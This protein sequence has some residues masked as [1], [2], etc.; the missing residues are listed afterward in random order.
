MKTTFLSL[1]LAFLLL[2]AQSTYAFSN[3]DFLN[4]LEQL[5]QD[6]SILETKLALLQGVAVLPNSATNNF[7][8]S[9]G[10]TVLYTDTS[11]NTAEAAKKCEA[12]AFDTAYMWQEI[13][14]TFEAT[15]LYSGTFI[16]G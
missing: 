16:A 4:Q 6:I 3:V 8:V 9:S 11:T 7:T 10:E 12:V 15:T 1:L 5:E 2:T 13:T 14:C